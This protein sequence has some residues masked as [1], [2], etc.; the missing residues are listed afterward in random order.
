MRGIGT[1]SCD[2]VQQILRTP[3]SL[4][5]VYLVAWISGCVA[6]NAARRHETCFYL[7]GTTVPE[8]DWL[9]LSEHLCVV[10]SP[11]SVFRLCIAAC[12][13]LGA[14]DFGKVATSSCQPP[15]L[16]EEVPTASHLLLK[17]AGTSHLSHSKKQ[18]VLR[19]QSFLH[20]NKE[21]V[22]AFD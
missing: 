5:S 3:Q 15:T 1:V 17:E 4:A 9:M 11:V 22:T 20:H 6:S 12:M 2:K 7:T 10:A 13:P 21:V 19:G 14:T 8:I 16:H 18:Q